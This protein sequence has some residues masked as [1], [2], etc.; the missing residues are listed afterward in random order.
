MI[1]F[2]YGEGFKRCIPRRRH[3]R[4][5]R[6]PPY[7]SARLPPMHRT[8]ASA[9]FPDDDNRSSLFA[10]LSRIP[11]VPIRLSSFPPGDVVHAAPCAHCYRRTLPETSTYRHPSLCRRI[12][13]VRLVAPHRARPHRIP[14]TK[15]GRT[16]HEQG[17]GRTR[18]F[19]W[20]GYLGLHQVAAGGEGPRCH[21]RARQ[22]GAGAPWA[23]VQEAEGARSRRHRLPCARAQRRVRRR[24]PHQGDRGELHVRE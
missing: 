8:D 13:K 20:L 18:I 22:R 2:A 24:V 9:Q 19:R 5:W 4:A 21:L 16:H 17:K 1:A 11:R 6:L 14:H 15:E 7:C 3:T 23:R 12:P 10:R